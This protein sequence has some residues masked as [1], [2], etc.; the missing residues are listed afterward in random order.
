MI[1]LLFLCIFSTYN[2]RYIE[3]EEKRMLDLM[4]PVTPLKKFDLQYSRVGAGAA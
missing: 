3:S 4:L 1:L 2:F